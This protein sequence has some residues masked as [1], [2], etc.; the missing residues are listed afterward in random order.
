MLEFTLV[1]LKMW[2][3]DVVV[4]SLSHVR[5]F[6]TPW[7]ATCQASLSFT[8]S[9]SLLR[10]MWY[11]CPSDL[12][13]VHWGCYVPCNLPVTWI[14][15]SME[16]GRQWTWGPVPS[17]SLKDISLFKT[18]KGTTGLVAWL[19]MAGKGREAENNSECETQDWWLYIQ[20]R[21]WEGETISDPGRLSVR[22]WGWDA[23]R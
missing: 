23:L 14:S 4:Q 9:Q 20:G 11:L 7:T 10:F 3:I 13:H 8:I 5:L 15:Y 18:L 17:L 12:L 22:C 1:P 19:N 2:F 16:V 6:A 21:N